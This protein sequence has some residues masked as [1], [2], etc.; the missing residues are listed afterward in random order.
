MPFFAKFGG[1][2]IR[3][4]GQR[5]LS[6]PKLAT[7]TLSAYSYG[8]NGAYQFTITNYDSTYT[9]VLATT[10]GS[11]SRSTNTVTVSGLAN[12]QT[13]TASVTAQKSGFTDSNTAQITGQAKPSCTSCGSGST[14]TE[15]CNGATCGIIACSS[16]FCPAYNITSYPNPSPNP[17]VGC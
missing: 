4:Y 7:P 15:G 5:G 16:G 14:S 10:A 2:S 1:G 9:Y 3:S 11:I 12:G 6:I 17:C 13:S 8:A